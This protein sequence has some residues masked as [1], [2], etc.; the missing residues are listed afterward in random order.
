M[1]NLYEMKNRRFFIITLV[2][3]VAF[4]SSCGSQKN[5]AASYTTPAD[6][7]AVLGFQYGKNVAE[8]EANDIADIF[9]VNFHPAKFK[10]TEVER[11][12][13]ELKHSGYQL[14]KIT[15]QQA[16][17][18]GRRLGAKYVVLGTINKLMDEYSVDIQVVDSV[19]ETT[20]AFEGDAFPKSEFSKELYNMARKI[21]SQIE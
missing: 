18:V 21:A 15:K 11:V 6:E 4:F 7:C 20:A 8:A 16:C 1:R 12:D 9:L 10:V 5:L 17:E 2:L 3:A 14:V 19:K 13:N